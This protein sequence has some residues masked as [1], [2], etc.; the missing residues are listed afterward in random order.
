MSAFTQDEQRK[1][2]LA[3][4]SMAYQNSLIS[5]DP[6]MTEDQKRARRYGTWK[7]EIQDRVYPSSRGACELPINCGGPGLVGGG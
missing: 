7:N 2:A 5:N 4:E 6:T 1:K 3:A